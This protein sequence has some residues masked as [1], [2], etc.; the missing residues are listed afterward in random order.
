MIGGKVLDAS[1]IAAYVRGDLA[2][3]TWVDV[4]RWS[5]IALYVPTLALEEVR[6]VMPDAGVELA[7]LVDHP[8]VLVHPLTAAAAEQVE[9]RL[10]DAG[11]FDGMAGHVAHAC[12]ERGWPALSADPERLL[13]VD[14]NLEINRI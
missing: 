9:R 13:R 11:V 3:A 6:A 10:V 7:E 2:A 4:A 5:G 14:S 12:A 1:L 8:T